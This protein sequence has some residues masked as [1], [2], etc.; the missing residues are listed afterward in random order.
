MRKRLDSWTSF[1]NDHRDVVCAT[2][3]LPVALHSEARFRRLL[4]EGRVKVVGGQ[5]ECLCRLDAEQWLALERFCK[6]FF[7]EFESC[8]PLEFFLAFKHELQRRGT[9]IFQHE[10]QRSSSFGS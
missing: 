3:L 2:N 7:D 8:Y 1:L 5:E 9:S 4:S 6:V 10:L